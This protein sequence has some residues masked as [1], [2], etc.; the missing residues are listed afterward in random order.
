M[1]PLGLIQPRFEGDL[2]ARRG[3]LDFAVATG[4]VLAWYFTHPSPAVAGL[5]QPFC[6]AIGW[7]GSSRKPADQERVATLV[8]V[9]LPAL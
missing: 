5:Q 8:P 1:S 4:E 9:S 3:S 6:V 2:T 7:E